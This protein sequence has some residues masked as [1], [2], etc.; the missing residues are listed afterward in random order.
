MQSSCIFNRTGLRFVMKSVFIIGV[1]S[2]YVC[3][4]QYMEENPKATGDEIEMVLNDFT[5]TII[6]ANAEASENCRP[7]S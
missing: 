6:G 3:V 1:N 7:V 2:G 5:N 4:Y